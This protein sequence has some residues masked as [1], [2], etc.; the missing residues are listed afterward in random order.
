M[1]AHEVFQ[2][3]GD[4]DFGH[5][6]GDDRENVCECVV[7]NL[8]RGAH[9]VHLVLVLDAAH[10]LNDAAG[11]DEVH[12]ERVLQLFVLGIGDARLL[13]GDGLHALAG[14]DIMHVGRHFRAAGGGD[15]GEACGGEL[16][17][18]LDIAEVGDDV[19]AFL[20]YEDIA[21]GEAEAADV[22]LVENIGDDDGVCKGRNL[23]AKFFCTGHGMFSPLD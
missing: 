7:G 3:G 12:A 21:V 6:G 18:R 5:F 19:R 10:L 20:R 23:F 9:F 14:A 16:F 11:G 2:L 17:R 8:L 1:L 4:L 13:K 22:I 15:D